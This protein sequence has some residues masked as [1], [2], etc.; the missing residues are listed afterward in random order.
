MD[1]CP[2]IIALSLLFG[3]FRSKWKNLTDNFG[4]ELKDSL[5]G[6]KFK[7]FWDRCLDIY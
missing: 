1:E 2:I 4:S 6:L 7:D 5:N 3:W